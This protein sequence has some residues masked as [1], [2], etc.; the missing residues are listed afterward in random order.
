MDKGDE[1][2]VKA[3]AEWMRKA[4]PAAD[5][6]QGIFPRLAS[7]HVHG[8]LSLEIA[9]QT[10]DRA[11]AKADALYDAD[12]KKAVEVLLN[13]IQRLYT[14]M[15]PGRREPRTFRGLLNALADLDRGR[16]PKALSLRKP[17]PGAP[18]ISIAEEQG[19]LWAAVA[20]DLRAGRIG[21][22]AEASKQIANELRL[23][24]DDWKRVMEWR[25][26][27]KAG[28]RG[29]AAKEEFEFFPIDM[30]YLFKDDEQAYA[31]YA[32]DLEAICLK[33]ARDH[34]KDASA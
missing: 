32:Q 15:T 13:A 3:R 4:E 9:L 6:L 8:L 29:E 16:A 21:S 26:A 11:A 28:K 20:L 2:Y 5:A 18:R 7:L 22:V 10:L 17:G 31:E 24:R 19:R 1:K 12:P 34:L 14:V 23:P 30:K 25:K 27:I 33:W